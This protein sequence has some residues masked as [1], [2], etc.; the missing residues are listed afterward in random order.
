LIIYEFRLL[1]HSHIDSAYIDFF[2]GPPVVDWVAIWTHCF[3]RKVKCRQT[4]DASYSQHFTC[5]ETLHQNFGLLYT[6]PRHHQ[7]Q[8]A[9][10]IFLYFT[11]FENI[12][13]AFAEFD[14]ILFFWI[15]CFVPNAF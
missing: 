6:T 2:G 8:C 11:V 12:S 10:L 9:H 15:V 3:F 5:V 13:F 4:L 1:G 7:T 14:A